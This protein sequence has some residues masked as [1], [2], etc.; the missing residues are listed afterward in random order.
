MICYTCSLDLESYSIW[1]LPFALILYFL[2]LLWGIYLGSVRERICF[3]GVWD[4]IGLVLCIVFIYAHKYL[5]Y[6]GYVLYLQFFQDLAIFPM[7]L[8]LLKI[9]RSRFIVEKLMQN[10]VFGRVVQFMNQLTLEIYI[11]HTALR[12]AFEQVRIGFPANVIA[13]VLT[14]VVAAFLTFRGANRI[15]QLLANMGFLISQ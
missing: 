6:R 12:I 10:M 9:A 11:C 13:F 4:I 15:R 14:S 7:L 1:K 3:K 8:F 5:M 2:V